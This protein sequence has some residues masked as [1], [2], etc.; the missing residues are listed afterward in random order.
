[1][2]KKKKNMNTFRKGLELRCSKDLQYSEPMRTSLQQSFKHLQ[3]LTLSMVAPSHSIPGWETGAVQLIAYAVN[4]K[5]LA[6]SLDRSVHI[7]RS[8]AYFI[9]SLATTCRHAGLESF[10]LVNCSVN[11][12]DLQ[13]FATA[14]ADT[15]S[16]LTF[17]G[18]RMITGSWISFWTF[19]KTIT[20]LRWLRLGALEGTFY[21]GTF[22]HTKRERARTTLDTAS[23]SRPMSDLLD[24]LLARY[25]LANDPL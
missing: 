5:H 18:V 13:Q 11:Q 3:S 19:L 23:S 25:K 7:S 6:L 10:Q 15:L 4:L 14:H 21:E 16:A 24:K 12:A 9:H 2:A 20:H 22:W 1:M 8:S 17:T